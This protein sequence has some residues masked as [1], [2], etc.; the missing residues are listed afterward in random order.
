LYVRPFFPKPLPKLKLHY[1]L[2]INSFKI[3]WQ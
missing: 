3:F 2:C 1:D